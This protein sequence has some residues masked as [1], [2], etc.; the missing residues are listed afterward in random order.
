MRCSQVRGVAASHSPPPATQ[1]ALQTVQD[2][3][4]RPAE[5]EVSTAAP[6]WTRTAVIRGFQ[7]PMVYCATVSPDPSVWDSQSHC[8]CLGGVLDDLSTLAKQAL[9][10]AGVLHRD[11]VEGLIAQQVDCDRGKSMLGWHG[12][13]FCCNQACSSRPCRF[14]I[15]EPT[16]FEWQRQMRYYWDRDLSTCLVNVA[17]TS[18]RY[19]FEYQVCRFKHPRR[20]VH[21][22]E[23]ENQSPSWWPPILPGHQ[24]ADMMLFWVDREQLRTALGP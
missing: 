17:D 11:I 4:D 2:S 24:H 3:A 5:V 18:S 8:T 10:Q 22:M 23:G 1:Q 19:G 14:Q 13:T 12:D 21:T 7:V 15:T 9:I 20:T 6:N 16:D